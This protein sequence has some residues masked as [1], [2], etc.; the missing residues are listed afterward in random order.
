VERKT[1]YMILGVT[2]TEGSRG[3]RAA[4]RDLAK[5]L[6]ADVACEQAMLTFHK[7]TQVF[8]LLSDPGRRREYD[9]QL[10]RQSDGDPISVRHSQA[11]PLVAESL[12]IFANRESIRPSF[13]AMYDRLLRNYTGIG[14][15]K[16]ERLEGLNLEVRLPPAVAALG[17]TV[18]VGVPTFS[19]CPH[20]HGS[21]R[22]WVYLCMYCGGQGTMEHE[23]IVQI[24]IPALLPPGS[25]LEIPLDGL[26]IHNFY[27]RLHVSV[28]TAPA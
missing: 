5:R 22:D 12:R 20:C 1:D 24:H 27:L 11:E 26:G 28:E 4:Y 6:H 25:V 2:N 10:R 3:I 23:E 19:R 17:C 18:P 8:D 21:G 7:V 9:E 13:A 15:P 14:V 16:A